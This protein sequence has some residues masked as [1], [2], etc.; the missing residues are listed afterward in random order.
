M[1]QIDDLVYYDS[2]SNNYKEDNGDTFHDAIQMIDDTYDDKD[3]VNGKPTN[4]VINDIDDNNNDVQMKPINNIFLQ[5][6]GQ[7]EVD[8]GMMYKHE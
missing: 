6:V 2:N 7:Q 8:T 5:P 3:D 1:Q 4:N